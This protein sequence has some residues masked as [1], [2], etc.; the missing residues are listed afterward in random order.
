MCFLGLPH[1][2]AVAAPGCIG[3]VSIPV[4][5]A[6][7]SKL[8]IF[9]LMG[10]SNL[11]GRAE[12]EFADTS[13]VAQVWL[14]SGQDVWEPARNPLNRYSSIRKDITMQKLG[15]GYTFAQYLHEA[16]PN[17]QI[18][19]VVNARGGSS[20]KEWQ[21]GGNYYEEAL[22]RVRI[23]Q[24]SGSLKAI[25]WHQGSSDR[26]APTEYMPQLK[27]MVASFRRDLGN[28][29]LFFVAGELGHWK[30]SVD[31]FNDEIASI[32]DYIPHTAYVS[33]AG[34]MP[35]DDGIHFDTASQRTLGRRYALCILDNIYG[36]SIPVNH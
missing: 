23:A 4:E 36:S 24:K 28:D 3:Q 2:A 26:H 15:P 27:A 32:T 10:Q 25:L 9:L 18:G 7:R 35:M 12:I 14:L 8:D 21:K 31:Q 16:Q 5:V 30:D 17:L 29:S 34:L 22:R 6:Q 1:A 13:V 33:A 19:L 11:A 20:I